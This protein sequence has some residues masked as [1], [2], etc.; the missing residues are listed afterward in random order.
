MNLL[1]KEKIFEAFYISAL[2]M[3]DNLKNL[4]WFGKNHK[5]L[6]FDR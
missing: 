3:E 1:L 5:E 4:S 6:F 2:S